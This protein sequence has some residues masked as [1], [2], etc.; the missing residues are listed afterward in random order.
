MPYVALH[1]EVPGSEL[2][3]WS[4][5]LLVA[6]A[7]SVEATDP[8]A[9]TSRETPIYAEP[10]MEQAR[11]PR[12]QVVALLQ[13][14][15]DA[16]T[17]V[18]GVA[19]ALGAPIPP[20]SCATLADQDWVLATQSQFRTIAIAHDLFIVPTWCTLP[21]DGISIRLDPGVAFGTGSHATTRLCLEWLRASVRL[22]DSV[23]DY[24]CGS[25]ILAIAATKFGA[26]RV[27]GTDVDRQALGASI[28][29]AER[30]DVLATFVSPADLSSAT[31]DIVVANIL[32]NPLMLLAPALAARVRPSGRI[33]LSGILR[34]QAAD[35][36]AAYE[37]WFTLRASREGEGWLLLDCERDLT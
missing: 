12:A 27:V 31:F 17:L 6:G 5:A 18:S 36:V 33:A 22:G 26:G 34:E 13:H 32:A 2:D 29:N 20:F 3:A 14:D 11:W 4:D 28:A 24:G 35:V 30:N 23:L 7:L 37:P 16:T 21:A 8:D 19:K 15:A 25:G 9:G 10:A 1:L